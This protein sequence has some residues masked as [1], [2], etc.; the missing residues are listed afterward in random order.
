M[1]N[2]T[3]NV[4]SFTSSHCSSHLVT[5]VDIDRHHGV[6]QSFK[7]DNIYREPPDNIRSAAALRE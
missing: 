7:V 3:N 6:V 4:M 2:V 5:A 1:N